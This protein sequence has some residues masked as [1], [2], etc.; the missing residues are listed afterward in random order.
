MADLYLIV[1]VFFARNA[2]L[3]IVIKDP[4]YA[5]IVIKLP[6]DVDSTLKIHKLFKKLVIYFQNHKRIY[7]EESRSF[8]FK[9]I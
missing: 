2:T 5:Y 6:K 9:I 1:F 7:Y 8:N 3:K 4:N